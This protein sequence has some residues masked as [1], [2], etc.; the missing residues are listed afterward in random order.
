MHEQSMATDAALNHNVARRTIL[1][2]MT[3]ATA[4]LA[5]C[6]R[7]NGSAKPEATPSQAQPQPS[8]S[9]NAP[10]QQE[11]LVTPDTAVYIP[12]W[13]EADGYD[14][15]KENLKP[16]DTG[17]VIIA[18]ALPS[19]EPMLESLSSGLKSLI[20]HLGPDTKISVAIGGYGYDSKEMAKDDPR[21]H[22]SILKGWQDFMDDHDRALD[23]LDQVRTQIAEDTG[24]DI[25]EIGVDIDFEYPAEEQAVAFTGLL[26]AIKGRLGNKATLSA[27]VAGHGG[28]QGID[29]EALKVLDA[30]NVMA[31]AYHEPGD[32]RAKV[33]EDA[34]YWANRAGQ[35]KVR[36][37]F[38]TDHDEDPQLSKP[39]AIKDI[40]HRLNKVGQVVTRHFFWVDNY[41]SLTSKHLAA[42]KTRF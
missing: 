15:L 16:G 25:E 11:A 4:L 42:A 40:L 20:E 32:Q 29:D 12:N 30:V 17:E 35:D 19:Q 1:A 41:G 37:G 31:Y 21:R 26:K 7:F 34:Q 13:L 3:A 5:A 24:R 36:L 38:T 28:D 2:A 8:S 9:P 39:E 23:M 22:K 6:S 33:V 10:A 18:F 27:A 14:K